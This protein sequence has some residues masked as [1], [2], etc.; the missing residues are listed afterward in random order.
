M[1]GLSGD[2]CCLAARQR[3]C[4]VSCGRWHVSMYYH[5]CVLAGSGK[6]NPGHGQGESIKDANVRVCDE[7]GELGRGEILLC[8]CAV[9]WAR[10]ACGLQ[11]L[12]AAATRTHRQLCSRPA[13]TRIG[14]LGRRRGCAR[15]KRT[16]GGGRRRSAIAG[17]LAGWFVSPGE[18]AARREVR[19]S[20]RRWQGRIDKKLSMRA[21]RTWGP[22]GR[23]GGG[24]D[25]GRVSGMERVAV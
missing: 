6:R 23:G 20:G 21:T 24:G 8:A 19:G 1:L 7:E 25:G 12:A 3:E 15:E 4:L 17:R 18:L 9:H 16:R 2:W 14:E 5:T 22:A 13:G 10:L 11:G